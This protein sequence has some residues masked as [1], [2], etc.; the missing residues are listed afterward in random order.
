MAEPAIAVAVLAAGSS[1]RFG[2]RDK[3]AQSLHGAALGEHAVRAIP[4]DDFA[5]AWVIASQAGHACEPAWRANGFEVAVND[6]AHAG[7]GTSLALAAALAGEAGCSG[8][9]IALADM[10]FVP[11]RH[12]RSLRARFAQGAPIAVS[13]THDVRMPP[14]IFDAAHFGDLQHSRGD[15]GARTLLHQGVVVPCPAQWLIDIDTPAALEQ[16]ERSP[17]K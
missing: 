2:A 5:K 7:M 12:F 16:A 11:R 1:Q 3:L 9:L 6:S 10:P 8:L 14:A 13:A 15:Q 4:R 17:P